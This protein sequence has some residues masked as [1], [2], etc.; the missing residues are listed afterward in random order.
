VIAPKRGDDIVLVYVRSL[1]KLIQ[2]LTDDDP[3]GG[4]EEGDDGDEESP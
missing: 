2:I 4:R 1:Y 3:E